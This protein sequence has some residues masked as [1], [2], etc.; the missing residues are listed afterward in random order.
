[1][2][3]NRDLEREEDKNR[4]IS[5][6]VTI[7]VHAALLLFLGSMIAWSP[8]DPPLPK[9]GMQINIGLEEIG[10]GE[11][12]KASSE[13][14][15]SETEEKTQPTPKNEQTE[16][17][18]KTVDTESEVVLPKKDEPKKKEE[19]PVKEDAKKDPEPK[20]EDDKKDGGKESATDTPD[21]AK[22]N[23]NKTGEGDM[24]DKKGDIN[25]DA[26][27]DGKSTGKGGSSLDIAGWDWD[28]PPKVND[29]S[30]ESGKIVFEI[31]VDEDGEIVSVS[32]VFKSVSMAVANV[33][34]EAIKELTFTPKGDSPD[35][36][37]KGTV[38][39]I[40]QAK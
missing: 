1:M 25:E 13:N 4:K 19:T 11:Q 8:P 35:G 31:K 21:G 5:A 20:K 26:L 34:K 39:F 24:G 33:Y 38:T 6:G 3:K 17:Q 36:I 7:G 16:E 18:V 22:G 10:G 27:Y 40:I 9:Y 29:R 32:L 2:A 15:S 37:T 23:G 30:S 12:P 14:K 28:S